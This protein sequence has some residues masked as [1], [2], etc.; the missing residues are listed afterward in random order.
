MSKLNKRGLTSKYLFK[1]RLKFKT[2]LHVGGGK[3]NVTNTDNPIVRTPEGF[4]FIPGSSFKGAFRSMVE[5]LAVSI[6]GLRTCQLIEDEESFKGKS[7]EECLRIIENKDADYCPTAIHKEF[8]KWKQNKTE[9]ELITM[10]EDK[11]CNTCTLFGSPYMASKITFH[12]LKIGDWAGVTQIRD[13]VV[14]DR[15]SERA[16]DRLKYDFEVVPPDAAFDMEIWLENPNPTDMG[17][18]C[19]G[20]NEF[21]SEMAYLGGI[22][23]RGLGNCRIKDLEIYELNLETDKKEERL[24]KYLTHT[25]PEDKME[26]ISDPSHFIQTQIEALF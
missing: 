2:A 26:N 6:P 17:L 5:K 25:K 18:T 20:L 15:D 7:D 11:L 10:L 24:M 13:G 9:T 3:I 8:A 19:I 1:G 14:I 12:D 4:P 21:L 16:K 23:S 22:K